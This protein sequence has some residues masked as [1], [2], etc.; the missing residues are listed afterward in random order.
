PAG[1]TSIDL[2]G[3]VTLLEFSAHWCVPC[4]ESYPGVNRLR[5]TYGPKGFQV[6]IATE[7]YGYFAQERPLVADAEYA[8]DKDYFAEHG[9]AVRI[10]VG[11]QVTVKGVD[12]KVQYLPA[13]NPNEVAYRVGGIPQIHLID[14]QGRIRLVMVGYDDANE[15]KLSKMI[16]DLLAG[17]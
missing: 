16:E 15:P 6:I 2:K 17:K 1:T 7:L 14:K 12:G 3:K 4:R 8:R 9:L 5:A 10:A 13:Q 11:D